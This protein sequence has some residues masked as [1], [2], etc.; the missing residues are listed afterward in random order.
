MNLPPF[1]H[2]QT[3]GVLLRLKVQPR[4]AK[5]EIGEVLGDELKIKLT[6]PPVDSAAN[7][8]LLRLLADALD[9]PRGAVQ[10]V[11]ARLRDTNRCSSKG[12]PRT[13]SAKLAK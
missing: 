5:N 3:E 10:L 7:E 2:T 6:A 12:F 4:A 11:R 13:P 1:L 8:A 9:C